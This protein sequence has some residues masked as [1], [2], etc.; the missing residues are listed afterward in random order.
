MRRDILLFISYRVVSRLYFQLPVLFLH[1]HMV[2]MGLHNTIALL[3]VYG[4]ITTV[5]ASLGSTLARHVRQKTVVALGELMKAAGLLLVVLGTSVGG[6][7]FWTVMVAQVIGGIGFSLAISTD[8]SLLRTVTASGGNDLFMGVQSRSQSLMFIATLGAGCAGGIL[9]DYQ[10]DW[11]F[12]AAMAMN[13]LSAALILMIHEDKVVASGPAAGAAGPRERV[14][15]RLD[16]DQSFW[17]NFYSLS[18]AFTMAPFVG[19]LPFFFIMLGVDPFLFGAVLSLF[20][21]AG[22]IA[23]LYCNAFLRRFGLNALMGVTIGCMLGSMTLFGFSAWFAR[24]GVDYFLV[25]LVAI[26][27]LGFGSGGVRPVTMGNIRM[28]ALKPEDRIRLLSTMERNFGVCNAVLLAAGAFV[29]VE[30]GFGPLMVTLGACYVI[31]IG[32]LLMTSN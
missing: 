6:T 31:L 14:R 18:R 16:R 7:D 26:A 10:A 17:M 29:L 9:Y 22:F 2:Q 19:F 21:F 8:S 12:L 25:G 1:L 32:G 27:L 23:A 28:G 4:L 13:L 20:T 11:P 15:L 30:Y 24:W 5:T 3:V